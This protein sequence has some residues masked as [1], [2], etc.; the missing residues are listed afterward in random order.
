MG[1]G[2]V[3]LGF[4]GKIVFVSGA[5]SGIGRAAALAFGREGAVVIATDLAAPRD[6]KAA[7]TD[8]GGIAE[9]HA[10]DVTDAAATDAL[11]DGIV[12]RHGRLDV[13]FN[14]AGIS[15]HGADPWGTP[16]AYARSIL[17]NQ[18]GVKNGMD[19]QLRHMAVQGAGAIVNTSSMAG[20]SG[21]ADPGYCAS[22]H[23]VI[24]LTRCAAV[25]FA[26][27]GIR[28]NAICPGVI[29]TG[30]IAPLAADPATGAMLAAMAPMNR[31]ATAEEVAVAV[32]FLASP[33]AS[34]ITGVALPVDGGA[35]AR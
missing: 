17:V 18:H 3:D 19:A 34:F 6:T 30:M 15:L 14:N 20:L 21:M 22:K 33:A 29:A 24:G 12:A 31:I 5:A 23:A 13:G 9:A 11:I 35:T 32:L 16:E 26:A 2:T 10:L 4:A 27:R 1:N 28:V 25:M 8:S 7:I